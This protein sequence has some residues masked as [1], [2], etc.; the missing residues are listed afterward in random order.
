MKRFMF[1]SLIVC[2]LLLANTAA[3]ACWW[4]DGTHCNWLYF[5][6]LTCVEN[7]NCNCCWTH[8]EVCWIGDEPAA[9]EPVQLPEVEGQMALVFT[10]LDEG[11]MQDAYDLCKQTEGCEFHASPASIAR[12][13]GRA[14]W[15]SLA[16]IYR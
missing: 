6:D 15:G 3:M 5:G 4:C 8:H 12:L 16:V 9:P 7:L 13:E 1:A 10:A 11:R 14:T 2:S